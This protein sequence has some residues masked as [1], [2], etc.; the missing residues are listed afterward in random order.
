MNIV[1]EGTKDSGLVTRALAVG[2]VLG[3][4]PV[5]ATEEGTEGERREYVL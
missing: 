3:P 1:G 4:S 2:D 5:A